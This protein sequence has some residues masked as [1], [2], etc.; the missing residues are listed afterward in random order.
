MLILVSKL[1]DY[2]DNYKW[3]NQFP[4][5]LIYNKS[6]ITIDENIKSFNLPKIGGHMHSLYYYIYNNYDNLEDYLI[7]ISL[8]YEVYDKRDNDNYILPDENLINLIWSY[9][10]NKLFLYLIIIKIIQMLKSL[11][12][13]LNLAR[14]IIQL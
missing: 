10:N 6:N 9:I 5:I 12:L 7:F 4:N 14:K 11:I 2:K 8:L 3:V 1:D 13:K